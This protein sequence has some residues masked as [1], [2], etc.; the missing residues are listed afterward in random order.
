VGE[1]G[2]I[3]LEFQSSIQRAYLNNEC[4]ARYRDGDDEDDDYKTSNK[5]RNPRTKHLSSI[6][7]EREREM[8][9]NEAA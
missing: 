4:Q 9:F 2:A 3:E 6:N 1:Q 5:R 7:I 8:N